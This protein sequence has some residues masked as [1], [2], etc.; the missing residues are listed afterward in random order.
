MSADTYQEVTVQ[1]SIPDGNASGVWVVDRGL[2]WNGK[3]VVCPRACFEKA[4]LMKQ[5]DQPGVYIL[6]QA[7]AQHSLPKIYIGLADPIKDRLN[8][9]YANKSFWEDVLVCV[10]DS[11]GKLNKAHIEYLESRMIQ[12]AKLAKR[13]NLDEHK[14]SPKQPNLSKSDQASAENFLTKLVFV[15]RVLGL[16]IFE[17]P[18]ILSTGEPGEKSTQKL[19]FLTSKGVTAKAH[20]DSRAFVVLANSKAVL[21]EV[22][23]ASESIIAL[24]KALQAKG[25]L[26][27][28]N[29]RLLFSQDYEF[30]SPSAAAQVVVGGAADGRILWKNEE[31]KTIKEL[32]AEAA[33]AIET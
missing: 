4:R 28:E 6:R 33:R 15:L 16:K 2:D 19:F 13:C 31:G 29:D 23:S 17:T 14:N 11:E 1:I 7:D 20:R 18:S 12:M 10:G 25:V 8:N 3:V 24:R 30:G 21:K 22:P 32:E 26:K 9:H 27:V 5:F